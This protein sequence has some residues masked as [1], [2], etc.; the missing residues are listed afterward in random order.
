MA[1]KPNDQIIVSA[2]TAVAVFGVFQVEAPNLADVKASAPGG[3]ASVN[4]HKSVKTAIWTSA[5]L[6]AG[7]A[8]LAKDPAIFIVGGLVTVA[9]GW[10]FMHANA[11][12]AA[13]GAIVAPGAAM[14]NGQPAPT[15]NQ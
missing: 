12:D 5:V 4:T 10:K 3:A 2:L 6:T 9:E 8:L 1:L 13:T 15:L 14:N 11:T 7:L